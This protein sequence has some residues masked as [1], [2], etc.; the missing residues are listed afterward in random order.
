MEKPDARLQRVVLVWIV[1]RQTHPYMG[2][3]RESG[4]DN[5]WFGAILG[6]RQASDQVVTC[7]CFVYEAEH[8]IVCNSI[9]TLSSPV[10]LIL[11][12]WICWAD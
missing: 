4:F 3:R 2:V 9:A 10:C 5:L 7:S 6:S 1:N 11:H 12:D 8:V